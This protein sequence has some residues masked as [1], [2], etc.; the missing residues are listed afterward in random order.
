MNETLFYISEG[1]GDFCA[2]DGVPISMKAILYNL[3]YY[4]GWCETPDTFRSWYEAI[5]YTNVTRKNDTAQKKSDNLYCPMAET[6]K[7]LSPYIDEWIVDVKDMNDSIYENYTKKLL[8][9]IC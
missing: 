3:F 7:T 6:I 9:F 5:D 4:W 1:L 2:D 8:C